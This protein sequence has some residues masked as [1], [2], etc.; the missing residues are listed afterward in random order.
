[1]QMG[2]D[3]HPPR[4]YSQWDPP[5]AYPYCIE[6]IDHFYSYTIVTYYM[7]KFKNVV[8]FGLLRVDFL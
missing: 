5:R 6:G 2:W 3:P 4:A 7:F 1:M 8:I